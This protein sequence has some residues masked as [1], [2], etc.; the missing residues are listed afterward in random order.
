MDALAGSFELMFSYRQG[1]EL[2]YTRFCNLGFILARLPSLIRRLAVMN[3]DALAGI[4]TRVFAAKGRRPWPLD[5]K[6][7]RAKAKDVF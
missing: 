7:V 2:V 1:H 5:Y 3:R 4:R 6:G